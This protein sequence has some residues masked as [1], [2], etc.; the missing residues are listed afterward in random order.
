[1][2]TGAGKV[3]A[4]V[5][6]YGYGTPTTA[7]ITGGTPLVGAQAKRYSSR[8]IDLAT[9]QYVY[10]ANGL[11]EGETAAMQI[12]KLA[13]MTVQGSCTLTTLG[14]T[15]DDVK[16]ITS[17][18]AQRVKSIVTD[19]LADAVKRGVIALLGVDVARLDSGNTGVT[20]TKITVRFRD[21]E[22]DRDESIHF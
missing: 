15:L 19:A 16:D 13:V 12:V 9:R 3:P 11:A 17:N 22:T 4:G 10:D 2:T 7:P 18:Y 1:M 6:P 21:L 8:K 5:T 14:H 20:R